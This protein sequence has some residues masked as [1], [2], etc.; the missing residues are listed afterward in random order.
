MK[1]L[2][3]TLTAIGLISGMAWAAPA[4][5]PITINSQSQ[6]APPITAYRAGG[7]TVRAS[8]T[9]GSTASDISGD[10]A[11]MSW[12]TNRT[13]TVVSTSTVSVVGATTG[14]V[15]FTFSPSAMNFAEG[16]YI[17]E[18]GVKSASGTISVYRQGEL[19]IYGSPFATGASPITWTTNMNINLITA[20]G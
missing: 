14:L 8:F 3:T 17:Y 11:W 2:L 12:S 7:L 10:T 18:V 1:R 20:T 16:S 9:D 13:S 19:T 4:P 15:D 5:Y 6:T